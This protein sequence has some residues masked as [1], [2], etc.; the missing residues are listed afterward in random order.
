MNNTIEIGDDST[1]SDGFVLKKVFFLNFAIYSC[2]LT[3][4]FL[5]C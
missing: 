4:N 3:E 2:V 1:P 5:A